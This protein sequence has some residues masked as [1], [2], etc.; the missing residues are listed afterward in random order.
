[1]SSTK[2][3]P[4]P[5]KRPIDLVTP[6]FPPLP[7]ISLK[8]T[9][10]FAAKSQEAL[11]S[12]PT[13]STNLASLFLPLISPNQLQRRF[14]VE[15]NAVF[16]VMTKSYPLL[17]NELDSFSVKDLDGIYVR[18]QLEVGKSYLLYLL[19]AEYRVNRE[20]YR[21]TY[22]NDCAA[23]RAYKFGYILRE[24]VTTFYDDTIEEKSIVEWCQAVTES[25]K[26][27]EMMM[28]MES[29]VNYIRLKKLQWIVICDQHNA[30]FNPPV[31]KDFPFNLINYLSNHQN[32]NI[33]II[34]SASANNEGYPTEMKD[35]HTHDLSSHRFDQEE[36]KVWCDHYLLEDNT[37]VDH[38]SEEAMDALF[39]TGGVPYEL[40]LLW[41]QPEKDLIE[42]TILYRRERFRDM[43]FSHGKF[44][45]TLID[46][47]K[48]NLAECISRM[49]LRLSPPEGLVGM[50]RQIFDIIE[51]GDTGHKIITALNPVARRA[52]LYYHGRGLM[53]SLGFVAEIVLKETD[54]PNSIKGKIS[55]MYITTMLELS[56]LFTFEFRK[57]ANIAKI[58]SPED[59]TERKSIEIKSVVRFL[60]N[61]LP[62]KTSFHK[63]VTSLFVPE[64]PNY[65]RFDFF[66]WDSKRQVMMG[67][68]VTVHSPFSDHPKMINSQTWQRFCFDLISDFPALGKL[69]LQ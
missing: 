46:K 39:W 3:Q 17:K 12:I 4:N 42:K 55:E 63:N 50:D 56:Q 28:M 52:L 68:Q 32:S 47:E 19:A 49:A 6:E 1:M 16:V 57:I 20:N 33:K 30:L 64:S 59:S 40:N 11:R 43:A 24:L 41:K 18:G 54:Y 61:K 66:L 34:V 65:P 5:R 51:D 38:E 35:W 22:I 14:R 29:L 26:E 44:Y 58:G 53:T 36:F 10:E 60:T 2:H 67:F 23:W 8:A 9:V 37:K 25:N 62:P 15:E 27:E 21:V 13:I 7:A 69:I 31:V 48:D 45:K